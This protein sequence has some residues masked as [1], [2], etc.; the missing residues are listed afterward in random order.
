MISL[1]TLQIQ[2]TPSKSCKHKRIWYVAKFKI[3]KIKAS[4][5]PHN[6]NSPLE[7]KSKDKLE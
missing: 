7:M 4:F 3:N 2:G 5:L 6:S 1:Y